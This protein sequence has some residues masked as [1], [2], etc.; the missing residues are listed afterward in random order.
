MFL[1]FSLTKS[2]EIKN[3]LLD[4]CTFILTFQGT[5]KIK[6]TK[7]NRYCEYME[8]NI[9]VSVWLYPENIYTYQ[10]KQNCCML[11]FLVMKKMYPM[12][13]YSFPPKMQAVW[14][15]IASTICFP[16]LH[17]YSDVLSFTA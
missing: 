5:K 9:M 12:L 7:L 15:K 11:Q 10:Y 2:D 3:I 8:K 17:K 4:S 1:Y 13:I 14:T 16:F 6:E